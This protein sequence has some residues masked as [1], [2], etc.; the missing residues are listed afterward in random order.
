MVDTAHQ[1]VVVLI[2]REGCAWRRYSVQSGD[3]RGSEMSAHY[4]AARTAVQWGCRMGGYVKVLAD[5]TGDYMYVTFQRF[6]VAVITSSVHSDKLEELI[7][8]AQRY[9]EQQD[10]GCQV[11]RHLFAPEQ[12]QA[13]RSWCRERFSADNDD[14][15]V[16]YVW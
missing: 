3:G 6:L 5:I 8:I 4:V 11:S 7:Q 12:K 15:A 14:N 10:V 2:P 13:V 16:E 9:Q 1:A